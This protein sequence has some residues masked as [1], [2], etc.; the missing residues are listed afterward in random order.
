MYRRDPIRS[1]RKGIH[2]LPHRQRHEI[3]LASP[4]QKETSGRFE[5]GAVLLK[6]PD[7]GDGRI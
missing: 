5:K 6:P 4:L 2:E 3:P 7:K 1:R